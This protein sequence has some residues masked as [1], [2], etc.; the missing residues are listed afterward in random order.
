MPDLVAHAAWVL[1]ITFALSFVYE[2][3]RTPAPVT[4]KGKP[5]SL[6][7]TLPSEDPYLYVI[8]IGWVARGNLT[9]GLPQIR[10]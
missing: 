7:W 3:Y 1:L 8:P 10:A 9:P 2:F 5:S 4:R 6:M